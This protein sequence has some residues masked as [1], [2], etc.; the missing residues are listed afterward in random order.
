MA[1]YDGAYINLVK[2]RADRDPAA[3]VGLTFDFAMI[4]SVIFLAN[5]PESFISLYPIMIV[6]GSTSIGNRATPRRLEMPLNCPSPPKKR[7]VYLD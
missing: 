2:A 3:A 6:V 1:D 7:L 5:S 4:C